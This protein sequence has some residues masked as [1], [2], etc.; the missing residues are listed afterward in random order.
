MGA[1]QNRSGYTVRLTGQLDSSVIKFLLIRRNA[2]MAGL[3]PD[4]SEE[5]EE[6]FY[7]LF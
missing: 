2:P 7:F 5:E 1:S 4:P 3:M 6:G